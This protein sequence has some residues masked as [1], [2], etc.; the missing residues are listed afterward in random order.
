MV[1]AEETVRYC[2]LLDCSTAEV[3]RQLAARRQRG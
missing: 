1:L 3:Y 2:L